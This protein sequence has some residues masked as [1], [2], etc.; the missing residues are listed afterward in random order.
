MVVWLVRGASKVEP[1][2]RLLVGDLSIPAGLIRP[3]HSVVLADS[4]AARQC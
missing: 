4:D 3:A 2:G 1:L